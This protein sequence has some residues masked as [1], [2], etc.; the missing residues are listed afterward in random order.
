MLWAA[1]IEAGILAL[2]NP[3][4]ADGGGR[5]SP[6][7]DGGLVDHPFR[8]GVKQMGRTLSAG[9]TTVS[10]DYEIDAHRAHNAPRDA[11][12]GRPRPRL[13]QD[14]AVCRGRGSDA[15][16]IDC[17]GQARCSGA[18]GLGARFGPGALVRR[19]R[20]SDAN[21]I[22]CDG[23]SRCSGACEPVTRFS[24]GTLR[25][26]RAAATHDRLARGEPRRVVDQDLSRVLESVSSARR[27]RS[28]CRAGAPQIQTRRIAPEAAE[29]RQSAVGPSAEAAGEERV[30]GCQACDPLPM[31]AQYRS[32]YGQWKTKTIHFVA[33]R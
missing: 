20:G 25:H 30:A 6:S 24:P 8:S 4:P 18:C 31:P 27:R 14:Q 15:N 7:G 33:A 9:S 29:A 2:T 21:R 17:D 16:R 22:D 23:Q 10:H 13:A 1:S 19:G 28:L 12:H 3:S 5:H 32:F 26:A 11:C